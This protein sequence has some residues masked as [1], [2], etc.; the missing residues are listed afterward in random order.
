MRADVLLRGEDRRNAEDSGG[1]AYLLKKVIFQTV[2]MGPKLYPW[3]LTVRTT[4]PRDEIFST[5]F[6]K[7]KLS[8]AIFM[9]KSRYINT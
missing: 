7:L 6:Q 5:Q 1:T 2:S 9:A 4:I 8:V 3:A